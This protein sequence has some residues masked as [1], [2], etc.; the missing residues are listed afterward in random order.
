MRQPTIV[1]PT[2]PVEARRRTRRRRGRPP[3]GTARSP[4]AARRDTQRAMRARRSQHGVDRGARR[5]RDP[6]CQ[7]ALEVSARAGRGRS[8]AARSAALW[9]W[10]EGSGCAQERVQ[11]VRAG[12]VEPPEARARAA[13]RPPGSARR[14]PVAGGWRPRS[15]GCRTPPTW[16]GTPP[17]R[18]RVGVGHRAGRR[19]VDH[20]AR[21]RRAGAL[22]ASPRSRPRPDRRASTWRRAPRPARARPGRPCVRW[23][24]TGCTSSRSLGAHAERRAR[25][26][27]G[28][29]VARR[30]RSRCRSSSPRCLARPSRAR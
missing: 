21:A 28:R 12:R 26:R 8:A 4:P 15:A 3:R 20:A 22:P 6:A 7:Q 11:L 9:S 16:T 17:R 18:G 19:P 14:R 13:R 10:R 2:Q 29:R 1:G 27:R 23:P 24:R 5:S 30:R 25:A